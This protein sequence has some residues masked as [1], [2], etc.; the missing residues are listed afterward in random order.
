MRTDTVPVVRRHLTAVLVALSTLLSVALAV[1]VNVATGGSLPGPLREVEWL[2]WP[3]VVVLAVVAVLVGVRQARPSTPDRRSGTTPA[4]LPPDSR[5]FVGREA[6]LAALLAEVPKRQGAGTGSPVVLAISG[7][8]GVG[9][10]ALAR[11]LAHRLASRY[12][13]GQLYQELRGV[14]ADPVDPD[15]VLRRLLHALGV[16]VEGLPEDGVAQQA[17]YRSVLAGRRVLLVL[18]NAADE[19]QVRPL[20]PGA[21][22][23]LVLITSR[24]PLVGVSTSASV[25]LEVLGQRVAVGLLAEAVGD[26][27]VAAEPEAAAEVVKSCGGLPLAVAIAGAR[28]RA[29]PLWTVADLAR[30]LADSKR[31]LDELRAG[32][33]DVRAS[34]ALSYAELAPL[35]ARLFRRLAWLHLD[36]FDAGDA[37]AVLGDVDEVGAAQVLEEL[38]DAQLLE[39][40][41]GDR[42]WMHDLLCGFAS[43]LALSQE[44]PEDRRAGVI[45]LFD[46]HQELVEVAHPRLVLGTGSPAD[47]AESS[48]WL[49][50]SRRALVTTAV[51]VMRIGDPE[52]A[53]AAAGRLNQLLYLRGYPNDVL[54]VATAVLDTASAAGNQ[55]EL[56]NAHRQVGLAHLL[57]AGGRQAEEPL[58]ASLALFESLGADGQAA[59]VLGLLGDL[60]RE[61]G[62]QDGA[63]R[64][65]LRALEIMTRVGDADGVA[66]MHGSLALVA[67]ARREYD[68]A[69]AHIAFA[70]G[71]LERIGSPPSHNLAW[72]R[73]TLGAVRTNQGRPDEA[74]DLHLS[75]L[76]TFEE[77]GNRFGA[78]YASRN[79]G[80]A[81]R[82][83]GRLGEADK[84]YADALR[85]FTAIGNP[86]GLGAVWQS[87][88]ELA[89]ARGDRQAAAD[90]YREAIAAYRLAE[91]PDDVANAERDLDALDQ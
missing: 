2:S 78:A 36:A 12:V 21:S 63:E 31:R 81:C 56:A 33:G 50:K 83:Q 16:A 64:L 79:L 59:N 14:S 91:Q 26:G 7:A 62:D 90:A 6:E 23:C 10:T 37:A 75:A 41:A 32:G 9:K 20:L 45:R 35:P 8:G 13:D 89:R 29:R 53:W 24:R 61:V 3:L 4:E 5:V 69:D 76:A 86:G 47:R 43:E 46:H 48:A 40:A 38:T 58:L 74:V 73:N 49:D 44:S 42:Y 39:A 57:G 28:L 85:L 19:R 72:A 17:L 84:H 71:E 22:G 66:G 82:R 15:D 70:I 80:I 68:E 77:I 27:R 87:I 88:G 25:H 67:L 52:R 54:T 34:F 18:D 55:L 60:R 1:A 65:Y 11:H 51:E 30:R